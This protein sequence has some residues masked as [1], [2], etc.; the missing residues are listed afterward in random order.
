MA[1][2]LETSLNGLQLWAAAKYVGRECSDV[3][4]A[5]LE[6]KEAKGKHPKECISLSKPVVACFDGV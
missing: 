6:C 4:L 5:Y 3:S 2:Q 1:E